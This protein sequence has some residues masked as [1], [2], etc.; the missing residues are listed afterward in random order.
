MS[1][2]RPGFG[3]MILYLS[4]V[5]GPS[6][7]KSIL[8]CFYSI[9]IYFCFLL[10]LQ[11]KGFT[12]KADPHKSQPGF[13]VILVYAS[14]H[15]SNE[16]YMLE[17]ILLQFIQFWWMKIQLF[18]FFLLTGKGEVPWTC[19]WKIWE[20][21]NG[22]YRNVKGRKSWKSCCKSVKIRCS[23]ETGTGECDSV[24]CF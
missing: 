8:L 20:H 15:V 1:R 11:G 21:A 4:V 14:L 19:H 24:K 23:W 5:W 22:F 18:P 9:K 17:K 16:L 12:T 10:W 6:S 13:A 3:E 2:D 7:N